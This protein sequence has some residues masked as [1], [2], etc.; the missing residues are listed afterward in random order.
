M[1]D[2]PGR[3]VT[4]LEARLRPLDVELAESWWVSAT[5]SSDEADQRRARAD[6]ARRSALADPDAFAAVRDARAAP[7]LQPLVRRQL[8]LLHDACLPQQVP[9]DLRRRLVEIETTVDSTF[10]TFRGSLD[11]RRV[12][13]NTIL[14]ILHT[15]DDTVLRRR[16]WE[17]S[18]QIGAEVADQV[19][20]LA[21]LRNEAA[22]LL[23]FRDHFELALSTSEMD[24]TRL[25][26][27]LDEVD[28]H[29]RDPFGHWKSTLDDALAARFGCAP[30]TLAPW[31]LDEP[32]FQDPPSIGAV[33]LDEL[34]ADQDLEALTVRT[35]DG[36]GLD[37]RPVLE[38]S[39]LYAREHKSQHAFCIDIDREGD[40]RVLCNVEPN[41]R[42]M[43]TMLHEFG[44]AVYDREVRPEVPWLAREAAHPLTTE[45][46]AMFFGRLVRDP[47]WLRTVARVPSDEIDRL[48]PRLAQARRAALLTFARWV[49]VVTHFERRLYRDP[50]GDLDTWWWDLVEQ[51]QLVRRP[52]GRHEP[53][54]ASK[55][56]L[57]V[58]PV[59]YQNYLYGELVASQLD[60]TLH[61]RAGGVVDRPA[62]GRFLVENVFGPG[63]SLRWDDL[64]ERATGEPLS[65]R[66]LAD[67]LGA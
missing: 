5:Q 61:S 36:L 37:V 43:D 50:D 65:A 34:F 48:V 49:L 25:F 17:A 26:A 47:K 18:K 67:Q 15:S 60:A 20:E 39:D 19:R 10:T 4:D 1:D 32:F 54:W 63:A 33:D 40:V 22:R 55:I 27:T 9:D 45:G 28:R 42:W 30:E 8:D 7:D 14:E 13:D 21:R 57:A 35:Y 56:H 59:Y 16:A 64:V 38:R 46:V 58:V 41:E 62:A 12:D 11:G 6:L 2:T 66:F 3:L 24:E 51:F 29:T 53:D 44:H 23:G 31:H 52:P